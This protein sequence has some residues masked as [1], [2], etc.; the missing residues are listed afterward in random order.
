VGAVLSRGATRRVAACAAL[1]LLTAACGDKKPAAP[2]AVGTSLVTTPGD[3]AST[4]VAISGGTTAPGGSP[5]TTRKTGGGTTT[6]TTD[7]RDLRSAAN[8]PPGGLA[9]F[10]LAPGP[11]TSI[12]LD[13]LVQPGASADN[14]TIA[15]L[16]QILA[17][18]SGKSVTVHGP[19]TLNATGNV[20]S[21]DDLRSL[22]DS[23]GRAQGNGVAVVHV[24][25]LRGQF[26]DDSAL[27]VTVRGDTTGVFPDQ[28]ARVASPLVSRARLERA[29]VTHE[30]GHILGLVDIYLN[31]NRDDPEHPGLSTNPRSV[32]YWAVESDLIGQALDGPPPIDFDGADQADL[33][34]IHEGA[35][36]AR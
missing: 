34:R 29:V 17:A 6:S 26:T 15:S 32:M 30:L 1:V 10:L 16:R 27:G 7:E 11:A 31:D 28:I 24:L 33:K 4:T 19:A 18:T 8:G 20:Y 22:A 36:S 9:G 5:S 2:G 25:Y 21:A 35:P 14:A 12:V 3:G 13:V 23:Q